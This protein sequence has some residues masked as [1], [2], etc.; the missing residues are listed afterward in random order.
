M[1]PQRKDAT[2]T[3]EQEVWIVGQF[4][5]GF[6]P[7]QVKRNFRKVFGQSRELRK[8]Q[9]NQFSFVFKRFQK[10]GVASNSSLGQPTKSTDDPKYS[11]IEQFYSENP[12]ASLTDGVKALNILKT[13]IQRV[14]RVK[15]GLKWFQDR[16]GQILTEKHMEER[17]IM[18]K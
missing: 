8:I 18:C 15:F 11:R 14:L 12:K 5:H 10:N 4:F 9:P 3:T 17:M 16:Y 13:T 7:I 1:S 2:F 6:S